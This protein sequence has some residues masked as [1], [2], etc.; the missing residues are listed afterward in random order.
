MDTSGGPQAALLTVPSR[1]L[2]EQRPHSPSAPVRR[3]KSRFY[4]LAKVAVKRAILLAAGL[5]TGGF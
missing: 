3:A 4:G 1:E 2:S 5:E